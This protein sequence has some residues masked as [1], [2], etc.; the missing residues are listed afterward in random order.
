MKIVKPQ[1]FSLARAK[2][3]AKETLANYFRELGTLL[4]TYNLKDHP[5]RIINIDELGIS[6]EQSPPKIV[7]SKDSAAQSVTSPKSF[8]VTIIAGGNALGNHIPPYYVF[9]GKRWNSQFL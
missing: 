7:C 6:T 9:P 8:N 5:E 1:T 3:A 4:T 2:C